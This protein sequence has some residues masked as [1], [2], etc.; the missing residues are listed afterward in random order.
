MIVRTLLAKEKVDD[1][2]DFRELATMTE[3]Y[4]GSGLKNLFTTSGYQPV[5]EL[6]QAETQ[7]DLDKKKKAAEDKI[8]KMFLKNEIQKSSRIQK[9]NTERE[10]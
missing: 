4:S 3:G 5:R 8:K 6:I 2:L 1:K 7:K 9:K 10:E